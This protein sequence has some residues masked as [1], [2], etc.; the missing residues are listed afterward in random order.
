LQCFIQGFVATAL[1]NPTVVVN[2]ISASFALDHLGEN[3]FFPTMKTFRIS[4]LSIIEGLGIIHDV[5][6]WHKDVKIAVDFH[7]FEVQ[8]FDV[9]IGH[10]VE[11]LFLEVSPLEILDV[12]L[13]GRI[14]SMPISRSRN[15]VS[16][17]NTLILTLK[18]LI[19]FC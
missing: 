14:Y 13:G 5:P 9:L 4:P 3:Y 15:A 10:P 19:K 1:Y 8:D 6:V 17:C 2:S 12:T 11:K 7:V 18:S 16:D